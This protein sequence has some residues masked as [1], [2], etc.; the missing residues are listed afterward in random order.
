[1]ESGS[2]EANE[3]WALQN[4]MPGRK[5]NFRFDLVNQFSRQIERKKMIRMAQLQQND[6]MPRR[7]WGTPTDPSAVMAAHG[8]LFLRCTAMTT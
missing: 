3:V 1:M 8:L 6:V 4:L 2:G 7:R 5:S